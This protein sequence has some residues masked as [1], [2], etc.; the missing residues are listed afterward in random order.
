MNK[1]ILKDNSVIEIHDE[2]GVLYNTIT[3]INDYYE[4]EALAKKLT[5]E[6]LS[7]VKVECNGDIV[8]VY[9]HL[10]TSNPLFQILN[11]K[12]HEGDKIQVQLSFR[13]MT[14]QELQFEQLSTEITNTEIAL[15]EVYELIG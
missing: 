9:T 5:K 3:D 11:D 7:V 2:G 4:L 12:E 1:L 6:N 8:G 15:C 14:E 10:V 13:E